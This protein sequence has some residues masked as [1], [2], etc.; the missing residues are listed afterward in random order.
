LTFSEKILVFFHKL[1][2][3]QI[4]NNF[5]QNEI[6][7]FPEALKLYGLLYYP[8]IISINSEIKKNADLIL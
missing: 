8:V 2:R 1:K 4:I 6:E 5:E 3:K 7:D